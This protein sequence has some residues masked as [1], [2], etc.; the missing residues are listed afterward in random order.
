MAQLGEKLCE[1]ADATPW[2]CQSLPG[3][4]W[5]PASRLE[6]GRTFDLGAFQFWTE[7][8]VTGLEPA[9]FSLGS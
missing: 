3:P 7:K 2:H 9:T 1:K 4:D 8:R 5:R 6:R